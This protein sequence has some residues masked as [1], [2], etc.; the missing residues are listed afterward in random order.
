MAIDLIFK[1]EQLNLDDYRSASTVYKSS[2][3]DNDLRKQAIGS[4]GELIKENGIYITSKKKVNHRVTK[5]DIKTK[6]NKHGMIDNKK[7]TGP[8]LRDDFLEYDTSEKG[9]KLPDQDDFIILVGKYDNV[10]FK[11]L[12]DLD[13]GSIKQETQIDFIHSN[14]EAYDNNFDFN[15]L[16]TIVEEDFE[17]IG[18]NS[19]V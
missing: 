8:K 6:N 7:I 15:I 13:F 18:E 4:Y 1:L 11:K 5:T 2:V 19:L 10:D 12:D 3:T 14:R 16:K 17:D 9:P